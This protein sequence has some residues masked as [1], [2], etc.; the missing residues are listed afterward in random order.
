VSAAHLGDNVTIYCDILNENLQD[1]IWRR[2]SH[3][4]LSLVK[5]LLYNT[6]P[7]RYSLNNTFVSQT[8]SCSALTITKVESQDFSTFECSSS[9]LARV[10]LTENC[11]IE[12]PFFYA[13]NIKKNIN[14]ISYYGRTQSAYALL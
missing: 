4:N 9:S 11:K 12:Q 14:S 8:Y 13:N 2:Y 10:N 3:Y 7:E 6:L 1:L 5:N